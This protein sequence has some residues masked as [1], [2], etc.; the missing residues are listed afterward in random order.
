MP[1]VRSVLPGHDRRVPGTGLPGG[2]TAEHLSAL[3]VHPAVTQP[4]F[5][6]LLR[7]RSEGI[8]V[9]IRRDAWPQLSNVNYAFDVGEQL[10]RISTTDDRANVRSRTTPIASKRHPRA[11]ISPRRAQSRSRSPHDW[12]E[13]RYPS[14]RRP[15]PCGRRRARRSSPAG[16][17]CLAEPDAQ[18]VRSGR[19]GLS[20]T[21]R[22]PICTINRN[23]PVNGRSSRLCRRW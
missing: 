5:A 17:T 1:T 15:A 3:L 12:A 16:T 23:M 6:E 18:V 20:L 19:G 13:S 4:R 8:L 11:R 9:T 22:V 10:I 21:A 14:A 2:D 7:E